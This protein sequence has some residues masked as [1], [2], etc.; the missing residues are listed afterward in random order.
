MEKEQPMKKSINIKYNVFHHLLYTLNILKNKILIQFAGNSVDL[1]N[2]LDTGAFRKSVDFVAH[3]VAARFPFDLSKQ[4]E[5][6]AFN[7]PSSW[8]PIYPLKQW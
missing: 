7:L 6:W 3:N 5:S 2:V 4:S 8:G 1:V